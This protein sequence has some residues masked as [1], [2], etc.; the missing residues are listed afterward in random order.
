VDGFWRSWAP[1]LLLAVAS[2]IT[3]TWKLVGGDSV[4]ALV[5]SVGV[6]AAACSAF[7]LWAGRRIATTN[8]AVSNNNLFF[9][10]GSIVW[11][12][13]SACVIVAAIR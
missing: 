9:R 8:T 13:G 4:A 10:L 11:L 1:V 5:A 3:L 6:F 12:G 7:V 2:I